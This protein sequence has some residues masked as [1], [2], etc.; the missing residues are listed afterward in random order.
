MVIS[1]IYSTCWCMKSTFYEH[2]QRSTGRPSAP[3]HLE[4]AVEI[5]LTP[6]K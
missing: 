4:L 1:Y 2:Q 3:N 6:Y 5:L